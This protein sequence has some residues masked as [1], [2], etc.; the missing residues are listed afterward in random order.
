MT[1]Q[2]TQGW[3]V[4]V[5]AMGMVLGLLGAEVGQLTAWDSAMSPAFVGKSLIHVATVIA[6]FV[7]GRLIPTRGSDDA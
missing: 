2:T 4:F 6:A 3:I 1:S 7:G 5:A